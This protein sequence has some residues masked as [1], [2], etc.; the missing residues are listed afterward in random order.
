[1]SRFTKT[2]SKKIN[3]SSV[4]LQIF[5]DECRSKVEMSA[6]PKST[7]RANSR[8]SRQNSL[9]IPLITKRRRAPGRNLLLLR[10][11]PAKFGLS[12]RG[13]RRALPPGGVGLQHRA[14]YSFRLQTRMHQMPQIKDGVMDYELLPCR[15]VQNHPA[16]RKC[17]VQLTGKGPGCLRGRRCPPYSDGRRLRRTSVG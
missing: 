7:W 8:K 1:M 14:F 13:Q 12:E 9:A 15:G 4:R 3:T 16:V 11:P 17:R 6:F 5:L 2:C 10:N